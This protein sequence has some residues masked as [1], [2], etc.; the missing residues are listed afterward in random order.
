MR[1][2]VLSRTLSTIS[3]EDD[4]VVPAMLVFRV[5]VEYHSGKVVADFYLPP[6]N[7]RV[8]Q[9]RERCNRGSQI[10]EMNERLSFLAK[11]AAQAHFTV[12][13]EQFSK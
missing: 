10:I 13:F 12:N 8:P 9:R 3:N 1:E 6:P 7:I 5:V 11:I 2:Y 4:A